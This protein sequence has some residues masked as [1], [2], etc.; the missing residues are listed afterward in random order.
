MKVSSS[1]EESIDGVDSECLA[2]NVKANTAQLDVQ[3]MGLEK[4]SNALE[5]IIV[6]G[7]VLLMQ[8]AGSIGE[9]VLKLAKTHEQEVYLDE[10]S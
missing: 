7:D 10:E 8:G 5:E 3:V 2:K 9:A 1:T 6:D 4:L